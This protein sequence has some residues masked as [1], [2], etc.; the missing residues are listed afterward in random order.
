MFTDKLFDHKYDIDT[1]ILAFCGVHP[2]GLFSGKPHRIILNSRDGSL[3]FETQTQAEKST[4]T[5][6]DDAGHIHII[7]VLPDHFMNEIKNHKHRT[8]LSHEDNRHLDAL[9]SPI[10]TVC[11]LP[12]LFDETRAG[13]FIR[14]V[15]KETCLDWLHMNAMI[16]PSMTHIPTWQQTKAKVVIS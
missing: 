14:D 3:I 9:L 11:Q 13:S 15:L 10:T 2:H 7:T 16:P 8:R 1:L 5:Q 12:D 4:Y 6:G